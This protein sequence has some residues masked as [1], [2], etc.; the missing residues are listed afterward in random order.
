MKTIFL[1]MIAALVSSVAMAD[2]NLKAELSANDSEAAVMEISTVE[3]VHFEIEL[4]NDRGL[5]LYSMETDAPRSELTKRYDFSNLEDGNYWYSVLTNNERIT[6]QLELKDGKV[7]VLDIRKTLDPHFQHEG[8]MIKMSFLNF[9]KE[10]IKMYVYD[11]NNNLLEEADL[12]NEFAI[13]K[14]VNLSELYPGRYDLVIA[15][16]I[17]TFQ[18]SFELD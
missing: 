16:D 1:V 10:N 3:M 6:K 15:N 2:G 8:D 17:E 5:E 13:H 4:I 7:H 18:H 12:G 11:E 9:E 14:G